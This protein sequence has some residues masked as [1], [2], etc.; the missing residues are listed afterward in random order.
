VGVV[1]V[2]DCKE[3]EREREIRRRR[4]KKEERERKKEGTNKE[5]L[6]QRSCI[7][8]LQNTSYKTIILARSLC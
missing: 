6:Q 7:S 3:R 4:R 8:V 2:S 5:M 1:S